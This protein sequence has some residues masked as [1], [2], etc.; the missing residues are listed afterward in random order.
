MEVEAF[1]GGLV[2]R[3]LR[4]C[5]VGSTHRWLIGSVLTLLTWTP[6]GRGGCGGSA[7]LVST[8]GF[9]GPAL[10]QVQ[11]TSRGQGT[12]RAQGATCSRQGRRPLRRNPRVRP[13]G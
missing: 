12:R 8:G 6:P 4:V 9:R 1:P 11:S 10:G 7:R 3:A 5:E 2:R 13:R